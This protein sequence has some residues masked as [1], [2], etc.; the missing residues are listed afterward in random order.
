MGSWANEPQSVGESSDLGDAL[1]LKGMRAAIADIS[2]VWLSA[3]IPGRSEVWFMLLLGM[4][5]R[6]VKSW[7]RH[8]R[9]WAEQNV[10]YEQWDWNKIEIICD[11]NILG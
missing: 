11:C 2:P 5:P 1:P 10:D 7:I 4:V 9:N 3:V 6:P 8:F